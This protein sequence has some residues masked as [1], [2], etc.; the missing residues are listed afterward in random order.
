MIDRNIKF[1]F[2]YTNDYKFISE[3]FVETVSSARNNLIGTKIVIKTSIEDSQY[4]EKI[5]LIIEIYPKPMLPTSI[6]I[7]QEDYDD[8]YLN[9]QLMSSI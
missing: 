8:I 4:K 3:K 1:L 2:D 5:Q 7:S 6:R 9:I